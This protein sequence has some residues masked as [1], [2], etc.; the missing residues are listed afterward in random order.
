MRKWHQFHGDAN[1]ATWLYTIAARAC[2][3]RQRRRSGEP[4]HMAS[5]DDLTP[6]PEGP[7]ADL[8]EVV[9]SPLDGQLRR[10]ARETVERAVSELPHHYRM[11]LVLKD[12]VELSVSEVAAIL[13]LKPATVKTR[14]HRGRLHLRRVLTEALPQ[15]DAPPPLYSQQ[16]CLDLLRAKQEALDRGAPFPVPQEEVCGR[17]QALFRTLDVA[18]E[19]C[20]EIGRGELPPALAKRLLDDFGR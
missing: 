14:V 4:R 16:I 17:C 8:P 1:P 9:E 15:K 2:Q 7:V 19:S 5:L 13:G 11:A 18:R 10:E 20:L 3:R 6:R 12:I